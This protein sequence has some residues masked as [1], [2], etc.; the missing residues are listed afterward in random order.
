MDVVGRV[1]LQRSLMEHLVGKLNELM[2][3]QPSANIFV[4]AHVVNGAENLLSAGFV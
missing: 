2:D 1:K 3:V 4:L